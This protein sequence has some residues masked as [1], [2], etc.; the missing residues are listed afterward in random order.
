MH[1]PR[2][3]NRGTATQAIQSS[4][5]LWYIEL[6]SVVL[7]MCAAVASQVFL[8]LEPCF[9]CWI[10]RDLWVIYG[11]MVYFAMRADLA[12]TRPKYAGFYY[13]SFYLRVMRVLLAIVAL[14][15]LFVIFG[16]GQ[17]CPSPELMQLQG[18][19]MY[20]LSFFV[21]RDC[22]NEPV[23][24]GWLSMPLV[25]LV[26]YIFW[27]C[28]DILRRRNHVAARKKRFRRRRHV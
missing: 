16:F 28:L 10:A 7:G 1:H 6:A 22:A 8:G 27:E 14:W 12:R 18:G 13:W 24:F 21:V 15:H 4:V 17:G 23:L 9:L 20:Y 25:M 3:V 2:K 19:I 5:S 11:V 26:V